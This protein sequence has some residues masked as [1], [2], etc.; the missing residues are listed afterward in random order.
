MSR[1]A[2]TG[3]D[4][5]D[6]CPADDFSCEV[7]CICNAGFGG[8]SCSITTAEL[9]EKQQIREVLLRQLSSYSN[10]DDG[11]LQSL[12]SMTNILKAVTQASAELSLDAIRMA[13]NIQRASLQR[14]IGRPDIPPSLFTT[15]AA[16]IDN[17]V[18]AIIQELRGGLLDSL[19]LISAAKDQTMLIGDL[20][21]SATSKLVYG[22]RPIEVLTPSFRYS[23]MASYIRPGDQR[24][25]LS[26]P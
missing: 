19:S 8:A 13:G 6:L 5:L 12:I 3:I 20:A 1:N 15:L 17:T 7:Y 16:S 22:Q 21:S 2:N 23:S 4:M 14:S 11:S 25:I 10:Y 9:L 18:S 26:S 24:L